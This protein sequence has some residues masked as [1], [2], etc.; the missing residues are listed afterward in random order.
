MEQLLA[1]LRAVGERW[2]AS[3]LPLLEELR[4]EPDAPRALGLLQEG[5]L[6]GLE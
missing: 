6:R 2:G 5:V 4:A 3:A 1:G